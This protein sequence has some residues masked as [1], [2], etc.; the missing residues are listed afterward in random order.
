MIRD[1][2]TS[3]TSEAVRHDI[4]QLQTPENGRRTVSLCEAAL[5]VAAWAESRDRATDA[6]VNFKVALTSC[7]ADSIEKVE[8]RSGIARLSRDVSKQ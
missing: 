4:S 5:F 3:A 2:L 8:A 1:L 7:P 6:Q